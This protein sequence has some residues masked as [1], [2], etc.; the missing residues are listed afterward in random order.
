MVKNIDNNKEIDVC[1]YCD[2]YAY[3]NYR[4]RNWKMHKL[5]VEH[6]GVIK[7]KEYLD[8]IP[9]KINQSSVS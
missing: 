6:V 1:T 9:L 2:R 8:I 3:T 4:D 5:C 7:G